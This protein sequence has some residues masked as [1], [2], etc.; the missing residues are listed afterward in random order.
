MFFS[1]KKIKKCNDRK[2]SND[3]NFFRPD[4]FFL[5]LPSFLLRMELI[6]LVQSAKSR[7][8]VRDKVVCSWLS[9]STQ[10]HHR[11]M[12]WVNWFIDLEWGILLP[13][14]PGVLVD[15]VSSSS[16]H[17]QSRIS[18]HFAFITIFLLATMTSSLPGRPGIDSPLIFVS[19]IDV[20][21]SH[22]HLC[23]SVRGFRSF[24]YLFRS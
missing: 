21:H 10:L 13:I 4:P 2:K 11:W 12:Q 22:P 7:M 16:A 15:W 24:C 20:F 14:K 9:G 1:P 18:F 6:K 17:L 19:I 3:G 23:P 8:H 5:P